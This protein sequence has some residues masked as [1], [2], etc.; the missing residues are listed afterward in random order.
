MTKFASEKDYLKEQISCNKR[1]IKYLKSKVESLHD[2]FGEDNLHSMS[3]LESKL[4]ECIQSYCS[5]NKELSKQLKDCMA[6]DV[7]HKTPKLPL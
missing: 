7:L 6:E 2:D 1:A 4:E 3:K 5:E